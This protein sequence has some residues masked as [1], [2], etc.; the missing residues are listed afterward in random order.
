M[1]TLIPVST[2]TDTG[3]SATVDLGTPPT[4]FEKVLLS[5]GDIVNADV[6][7][8]KLE[9]SDNASGGPWFFIGN[10]PTLVEN[11]TVEFAFKRTKRYVRASTTLEFE[12]PDPESPVASEI[13]LSAII[14]R[15]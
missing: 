6:V 11:G 1:T 10:L 3:V 7:S 5:A 14:L 4:G 15:E 13:P 12:Q 2:L 8:V 9:E